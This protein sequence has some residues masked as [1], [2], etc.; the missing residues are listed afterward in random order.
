MSTMQR[1]SDRVAIVTGGGQG[2]GGATAR[3]LAEEGAR[4]LVVDVDAEAAGRNV[5]AIHASG[6]VADALERDIGTEDGV[7]AM[8]ERAVG[9]WGKLDIVVNNAYAGLG[10]ARVDAVGVTE[11]AWDRGMHIGLKAMFRAA[12]YAVPHIRQAGGGVM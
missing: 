4:V 12:K 11:E 3:R 2:I 9:S 7:R 6:G 10:G 8:V 5:D 1:L